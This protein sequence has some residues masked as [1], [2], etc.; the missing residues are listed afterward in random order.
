M[1]VRKLI[2]FLDILKNMKSNT[3]HVWVEDGRQESVADHSWRLA[4]MAL[5]I[6]DE[7]EGV[8][9]NKVVKMCLI[10][11]FG[12]AITGDIPSFYKTKSDSER[13][14]LAVVDLIKKLPDRVGDEFSALFLE[15]AERE[16]PESKLFKALDGI[17]A[18]ISH[19]ESPLDTWLELEHTENLIYGTENAAY[20][21]YLAELR[22]EVRLDSIKKIECGV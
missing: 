13:E 22:E 17:E 8:D 12:E 20:N 15:M 11:D 4:V 6:A 21:K 18:C 1:Q 10:H 14:D 16:S 19:N 7:F 5:L 3:R 9:I 2:E